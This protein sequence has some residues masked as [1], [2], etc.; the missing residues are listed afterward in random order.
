MSVLELLHLPSLRP[1]SKRSRRRFLALA[2]AVLA[3]SGIA[4]PAFAGPTY[5]VN[6]QS[7]SCSDT[8]PGTQLQPYCTINAAISQHGAPGVT[9]L[10]SPGTYREQVEL[11]FS[12]AVND[13]FKLKA[14]GGPV[15]VDAANDFSNS[16][17]WT[18]YSGNV[19]RATTV[20]WSPKQVFSDGARLAA[21]TV[22]VGS[23]PSG[24]Y[25]Y[26]AGQGLYVNVGGG[27]PG[28][29]NLLVGKRTYGIRASART[30]FSIT[31]FTV[32]HSEDRGIFI[33]SGCTDASIVGNA[34]EW[35]NYYGIAIS[36]CTRLM[37]ANNIS[38]DNNSHGC[39][40]TNTCTYV[41]FQ[42]NLSYNNADPTQRIAN[43]VYVYGSSNCLFQRNQYH[44]NQ[45]TGQHFQTGSNNN[46]SLDNRS[47]SNGDHGYDHL[48]STGNIHIGDEAWGNYKDGFSIEGTAT[49]T[50]LYNCIATDN[51]LTTNEFDLWVENSSISGFVS[52]YNLVWNSTA[53][54]PIKYS[55]TLYPTI[56]A[57]TA[58]T[59]KDAHSIQADPKF[60]NPSAGDFHLL[61]GSPA[62]DNA[63]SSVANWPA[64]DADMRPHV[65][66]PGTA[67]A[68]VGPISYGDRGPLEFVGFNQ[69]PV[70]NLTVTP[71][72][73]FAPLTVTADGSGSYDPDGSIVAYTIDFGD[74][75]VVGPGPASSASHQ[76]TTG[77]NRTV[78]LTV[79]DDHSA[80][81]TATQPVSVTAVNQPPNGTITAPTGS[82]T[83]KAGECVNF[84]GGGTDPD[85]NLPLTY[86]WDFG[87]G[88]PNTTAQNPGAVTFDTP[89]VYTVSFTVTDALGLADPS[90]ETHLI[91]V[92][93]RDDNP[94]QLHWTIIGPTAVTFDW[95][96]TSSSIRY[97]T[98]TAYGTTVTGVA[99]SI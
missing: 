90:P 12:G 60:T 1:E 84:T 29:H 61:P 32:R 4:A 7:G 53:Q 25:E 82:V 20:T 93:A 27:N 38:H 42:D 5:Y 52:D 81:T 87:G 57:F 21:S 59:G 9:I 55:T 62:I 98:T 45:D 86:A 22:A 70:A 36:G 15:I 6:N 14:L 16:A 8:G 49:G 68:G 23:L 24:S 65:D 41:T 66:D 51:G 54:R 80:T 35:A 44:H 67:N 85:N 58:A 11:S 89:G 10:V 18:Q 56:A 88:A 77:G 78:T 30:W 69:S 79:R 40:I 34:V 39:T 19:W 73:G 48:R 71:A 76:Y 74:G 2:S 75:T 91:T 28:P 31:G 50:Q 92:T 13:T 96:G 33:T 95:E 72:S 99:P 64:T 46:V 63:N 43:G 17:L 97:G 37:V 3:L 83:V 94:R 47:W 26:V